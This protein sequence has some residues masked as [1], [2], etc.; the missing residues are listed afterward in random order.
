VKRLGLRLHADEEHWI[1]LSDLMTGLMFLFLLIALAYMV[2]AD[3]QHAAT[4]Q[5]V[6]GYTAT[7]EQL[8]HDL[9]Q[10][11]HADLPGWG[12]Q[13]EENTLSIRFYSQ[14]VLFATGSTQLQPRFE[15]IL[16]EFFPRYMHILEQPKYRG[17]VSEVRIE[18]YTSSRWRPGATFEESYIGNMALSQDRARSV[19]AYVLELPAVRPER[20]WLVPLLT[21]NGLSFSHL[22]RRPDGSEDPDASQR[23]EFRVRT[24]ADEQLHRVLAASAATLPTPE[25]PIPAIATTS[26]P[27]YPSWASP[28]IGRPVRE[29][30]PR[31]TS[32]CMGYLAGVI[33]KYAGARPGAELYGWGYDTAA[34]APVSRVLFVDRGGTI[35]GAG[36]GGFGRPD[37][38][39]KLPQIQSMT[40]GWQGYVG[41]TA[42]PAETWGIMA[43]PGTICR[44]APANTTGGEVP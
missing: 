17:I 22:I 34:G 6:V 43:E 39:A 18:G 7:R 33:L 19:L 4:K 12:A 9:Y 24:N 10:E 26:M 40:T 42:R 29:F 41:V 15:R 23:V 36:T 21:A 13:L 16:T 35:V 27:P 44:F 8:Y 31:Q 20:S 32:D 2:Q 11:F 37:V 5:I 3:L 30:F 14:N 25:H 38:P 28:L 1:P